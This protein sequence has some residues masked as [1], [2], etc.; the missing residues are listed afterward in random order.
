MLIVD[1]NFC[2][3]APVPKADGKIGWA[4]EAPRRAKSWQNFG[5]KTRQSLKIIKNPPG[6]IRQRQKLWTFTK[7]NADTVVCSI[8]YSDQKWALPFGRF[9]RVCKSWCVYFR[10]KQILYLTIALLLQYWSTMLEFNK[11]RLVVNDFISIF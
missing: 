9:L 11:R 5:G 10:Y 2:V 3:H 4:V 1:T 6:K 7:L 8:I